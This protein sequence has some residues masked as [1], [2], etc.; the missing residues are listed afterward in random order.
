[1]LEN[2]LFANLERNSRYHA[3]NNLNEGTTRVSGG[4]IGFTNMLL[5]FAIVLLRA[6][7]ADAG[8][9]QHL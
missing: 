2:G 3:W 5:K 1:M 8:M 7:P 4:D 9:N 6:R